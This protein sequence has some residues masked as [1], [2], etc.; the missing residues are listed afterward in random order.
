MSQAAC[1]SRRPHPKHLT[2]HPSPF[3]PHPSYKPARL[4]PPVSARLI[5]GGPCELLG[6]AAVGWGWGQPR[7]GAGRSP[8]VVEVQLLSAGV[9][10]LT[11][12]AL[13]S[14]R[15]KPASRSGQ[16][17]SMANLEEAGA[18]SGDAPP[19]VDTGGLGPGD[20]GVVRQHC[21]VGLSWGAGGPGTTG[22][23]SEP[24]VGR[25]FSLGR[26]RWH[27]GTLPGPQSPAVG[28]IS[29]CVCVSV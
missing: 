25:D 27:P 1:F 3:T 20:S 15:L 16:K 6:G 22:V 17:G 26:A 9:L 13:A 18:G 4:P 5:P 11:V 2:P 19:Q 7:R 21:R 12:R 28:L 24:H 29:F 8:E 23:Q 10:S 14:R